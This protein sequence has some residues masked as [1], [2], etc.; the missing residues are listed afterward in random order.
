MPSSSLNCSSRFCSVCLT[1]LEL[2]GLGLMTL[3]IGLAH[4][5]IFAGDLPN[6]A[7]ARPNVVLI[8]SDDQG[9]GDY[10]FM[11]HAQL[12]TPNLDRLAAE[13]LTYRRAY[14]PSSLCCPSLASLITGRYPH[15]HGI[16]CNDPPIPPGTPAGNFYST[17]AFRNG[18]ARL[19]ERM[20]SQATLP[21]RLAAA[22]YRSLQ[23]GKWWQNDF[24]TGGFSD[25]M[26]RGDRHGDAGL[27]IG[28]KTLEPIF[29]FVRDCQA[30]EQPFFVWYAPFLP[31]AP[32]D[33]PADI[34]AAS[35]PSWRAGDEESIGPY[36]A[37][38]LWHDRAVGELL[39]GLR[40][41]NCEQN[42]LV[43]YVTDNGWIPGPRRNSYAPKSKQS[44]Y[45]G[46]LR[47]PLMIR[48]PGQVEPRFDDTPVSSLDIA[49]TILKACGLETTADLTGVDLRD[50]KAVSERPAIFGECHT[51]N[52]VDLD[53]PASGLRWRWVIAGR[54][55]LIAPAPQNEPDGAPE[56]YNLEDDPQEAQ[57][58]ASVQPERLAAMQKL[59]DA[60]WDGRD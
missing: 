20:A 32:H 35:R 17:D 60:W 21:R 46:G 7:V 58:Q 52:A 24:R 14:V 54:W 33:A 56:L 41:L 36:F 19:A 11:G 6:G 38:V 40:R 53:R 30:V 29:D 44:P 47:T 27:E 3:L 18:R 49:P 5:I 4:S 37:N 23:T 15:E 13:S 59:L 48:W 12:Q 16:T 31:H 10:G 1:R 43:I 8:I 45:D 55:K 51:H 28:R 42:T 39:D 22:G 57:N 2:P 50:Q 9:W 26:T 25:G 34:V